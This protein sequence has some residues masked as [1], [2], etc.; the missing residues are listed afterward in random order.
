MSNI[1]HFVM[2]HLVMVRFIEASGSQADI[3]TDAGLTGTKSVGLARRADV[4]L[5]ERRVAG[6]RA[7]GRCVQRVVYIC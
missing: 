6:H 4:F 2:F 5:R 1:D 3:R 7:Q